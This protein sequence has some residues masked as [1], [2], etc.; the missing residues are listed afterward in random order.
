MP[1][2]KVDNRRPAEDLELLCEMTEDALEDQSPIDDSEFI[3]LK[4]GLGQNKSPSELLR[5]P[6]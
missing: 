6:G 1:A 5:L 2:L 4:A 3:F